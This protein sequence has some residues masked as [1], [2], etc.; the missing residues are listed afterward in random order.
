MRLKGKHLSFVLLMFAKNIVFRTK[1]KYG[2]AAE[3][4]NE[5]D[6]PATLLRNVK[7]TK[8]GLDLH[9]RSL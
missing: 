9:V 3:I 8:Y 1:H 5:V 2:I 7:L 4:Y 6:C